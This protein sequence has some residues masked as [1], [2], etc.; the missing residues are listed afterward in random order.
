M[1]FDKQ[2][3]LRKGPDGRVHSLDPREE[4]SL[5]RQYAKVSSMTDE[6][7]KCLMAVMAQRPKQPSSEMVDAIN[8]LGLF[9]ATIDM[10]I[11]F[12]GSDVILQL[13]DCGETF[14]LPVLKSETDA[15]VIDGELLGELAEKLSD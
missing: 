14:V 1:F 8:E 12:T 2:H 5:Q 11:K 13:D 7:A 6:E 9:L 10:S 4:E 3:N 15:S